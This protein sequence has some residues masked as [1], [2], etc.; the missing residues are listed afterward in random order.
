MPSRC[1]RHL[2]HHVE[3]APS[4]LKLRRLRVIR[5]QAPELASC[6]SKVLRA[7]CCSALWLRTRGWLSGAL[8]VLA[9]LLM[10]GLVSS[11]AAAGSAVLRA[12]WG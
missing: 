6:Q 5:V 10:V 4:G 11:P 3:A 7:W 9:A 2:I 12:T 1:E 8:P